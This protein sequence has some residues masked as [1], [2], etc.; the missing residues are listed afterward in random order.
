VQS[1]ITPGFFGVVF[2]EL[3]DDLHQV[4]ADVG[5]LGEDAAADT[6]HRGAERFA[7]GEAD[8]AGADEVARAGTPGCRS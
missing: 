5:D 3:E 7:D 6:E 4:G 8:E 2:L 1:A